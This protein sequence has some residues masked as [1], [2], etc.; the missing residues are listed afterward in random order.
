MVGCKTRR[1]DDLY[2]RWR[3][4]MRRSALVLKDMTEL[5]RLFTQI[6]LLR[7]GPQ[8]LPASVLLLVLTIAAYLLI[9]FLINCL[10]LPTTAAADA[11][12]SQ[13]PAQL[14]LYAL[15]TFGWYAAL[16]KL[17]RRSERTLQTS[18]AVFGVMIVLIPPLFL[19]SWL[20]IRFGPDPLWGV[21]AQ[22][23]E[24]MV[25]VWIIAANSY[26]VKAALEWSVAASVAL[27]ILQVA[28]SVVLIRAVFLPLQG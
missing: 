24:I 22:L 7:R 27:V 12:E 9:N 23:L 19:S 15:F 10:P 25:Q 17:A 2:N 4:I 21:P 6:A 8:D 16:L 20:R 18:T 3:R 14:F 11:A 5:L 13:F 26:I 1:D 28:A